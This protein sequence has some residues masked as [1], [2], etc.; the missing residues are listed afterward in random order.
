MRDQILS[1][2]SDK[3]DFTVMYG[4]LSNNWKNNNKKI[5]KYKEIF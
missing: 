5:S 4:Y 1:S 2:F 3:V